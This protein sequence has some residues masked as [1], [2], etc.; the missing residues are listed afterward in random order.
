MCKG[1]VDVVVAPT[2]SMAFPAASRQR[3]LPQQDA[4]FVFVF[5]RC[6]CQAFLL[7]YFA[8][9]RGAHVKIPLR[10]DADF[11]RGRYETCGNTAVRMRGSRAPA[12]ATLSRVSAFPE[13]S[14]LMLSPC[15]TH[16]RDEGQ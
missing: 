14:P 7:P 11:G 13:L 3:A 16:I 15:V 10:Q 9:E 2:S 12:L 4:G 5:S 6:R 8:T 1:H